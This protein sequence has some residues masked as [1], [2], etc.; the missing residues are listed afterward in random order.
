MNCMIRR[1]PATLRKPRF[2][3]CAIF[4]LRG[5]IWIRHANSYS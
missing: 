4:F 2:P 3:S 1:I 5:Y